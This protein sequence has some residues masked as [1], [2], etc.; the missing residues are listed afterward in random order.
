MTNL[1]IL[2]AL[3]FQDAKLKPL[4]PYNSVEPNA[5][6]S[7]PT[8]VSEPFWNSS[9]VGEKCRFLATH[10]GSKSAGEIIYF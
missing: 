9:V 1:R 7:R 4:Y 3:S 6:H 5:T 2:Y 8:Y 10:R